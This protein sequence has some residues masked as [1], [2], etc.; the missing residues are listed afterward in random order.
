V[1]YLSLCQDFVSQF[2]LAGGTGPTTVVNQTGELAN[3]VRWIRDAEL[4]LNNLWVDWRF[5]WLPYTGTIAA[6]ASVPSAVTQPGVRVR[7][8]ETHKLK[9]RVASPLEPSWSTLAFL[10]R[11]QFERL[12]DPDVSTPGRPEAFTVMPDNTIQFDKSADVIYDVKGSYFRSPEPM[13]E[14]EHLPLMPAEYHRL[15]LVRACIMYADREDAPELVNGATAEYPDLLEKLEAS[16][17]E[18][19]LNRRRSTTPDEHVSANTE[20]WL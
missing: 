18:G 20:R 19:Q 8:W 3:V 16:Q 15:I 13:T 7:L 14:N 10:P 11:S 2:G 17:L 5:L 6:A 9:I 12:Y 1:N 4:Y